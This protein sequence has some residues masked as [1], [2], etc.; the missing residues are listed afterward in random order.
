[1]FL[2]GDPDNDLQAAYYSLYSLGGKTYFT[3]IAQEAE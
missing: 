3:Q 1:V 2:A